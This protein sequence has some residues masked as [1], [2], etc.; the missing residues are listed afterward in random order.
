VDALVT[1]NGIAAKELVMAK[2]KSQPDGYQSLTPDR[3]VDQGDAA[4]EFYKD[5][6]GATV[7]NQFHEPD[8]GKLMHA[9]LQI[10]GSRFWVTEGMQGGKTKSPPAAGSSSVVLNIYTD[11][12]DALFER[13]VEAGGKS[14]QE[15]ADQFWGDRYGKLSDPF[16]HVWDILTN[17]EKLTPEAVRQRAREFHAHSGRH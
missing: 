17:Q 9:D 11:D 8:S 10:G 7:L 1:A 3:L 2:Q 4:L 15:P 12:C 5:A 6:F 14:L 16:G 13:A